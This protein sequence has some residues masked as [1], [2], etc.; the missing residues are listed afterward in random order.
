MFCPIKLHV[1]KGQQ[2]LSS[3]FLLFLFFQFFFDEVSCDT[4]GQRTDGKKAETTVP[5]GPPNSSFKNTTASVIF[6]YALYFYIMVFFLYGQNNSFVRENN[7]NLTFIY[8]PA[9]M[10]QGLLQTSSN[11]PVLFLQTSHE[12][13]CSPGP[14]PA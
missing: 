12:D 4:Q 7:Q 9:A 6:Q 14:L 1:R 3:F 2:L 13:L 10:C 8:L 5:S 11:P